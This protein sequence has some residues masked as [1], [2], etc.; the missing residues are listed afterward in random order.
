MRL[1]PQHMGYNNPKDM[2][3]VALPIF[4]VP[5]NQLKR[6]DVTYT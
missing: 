4:A 5:S 2:S 6:L 3:I 1:S